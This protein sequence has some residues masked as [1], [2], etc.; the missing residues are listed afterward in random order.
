MSD[1]LAPQAATWVR[2]IPE[3]ASITDV[4]R[5]WRAFADAEPDPQ[6]AESYRA[7]ADKLD[8]ILALRRGLS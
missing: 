7:L 2:A 1:P 5:W 8:D 4:P 6:L 3:P